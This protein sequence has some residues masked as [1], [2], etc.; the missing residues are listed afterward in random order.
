MKETP[1]KME[2]LYSLRPTIPVFRFVIFHG[3]GVEAV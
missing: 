1:K 2:F 3:L